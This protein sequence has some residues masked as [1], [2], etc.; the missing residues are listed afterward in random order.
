MTCNVYCT[1]IHS[2]LQMSSRSCRPSNGA[3]NRVHVRVLYYN[4]AIFAHAI[5]VICATRFISTGSLSHSHTFI[6]TF[7]RSLAVSLSLSHICTLCHARS[8]PA[9]PKQQ[10]LFSPLLSFPL[11]SAH[12]PRALQYY[13]QR[14]LLWRTGS[15]SPCKYV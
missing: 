4:L 14:C 2:A 12:L 13:L 10:R 9:E 8:L 1:Y 6:H 7:T 15:T 11:S 3:L 5:T